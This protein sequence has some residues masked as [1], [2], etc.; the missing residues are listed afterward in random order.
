MDS[1]WQMGRILSSTCSLSP[2]GFQPSLWMGA[3]RGGQGQ[4]GTQGMRWPPE[5]SVGISQGP[6]QGHSLEPGTQ[7]V[8]GIV[9]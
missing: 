6:L 9:C 1:D 5:D 8:L 3:R 4:R 7:E 2:E